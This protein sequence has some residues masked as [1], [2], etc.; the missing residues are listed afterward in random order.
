[1]KKDPIVEKIHKI[2]EKYAA[3]F[4]RWVRAGVRRL[5]WGEKRMRWSFAAII[6][7]FGVIT[8]DL[9]SLK[10]SVLGISLFSIPLLL[11]FTNYK[12]LHIWALWG[13][14]FFIFQSLLS[15]FLKNIDFNDF[16]TLQPNMH[17]I[18]DVKAG[19]PGINGKQLVT[20]DYKGFR[21]TR[22]IDYE[23]SKSYR[24][25]AI[26]GST[27]EQIYLDDRNTW[28]HLLQEHLSKTS[29]L[30]VINTGVSG[31]R[32]KHHLATFQKIIG[33]HPDLVIFLVGIND[34]N[35][36]I[37]EAF[38]EDN[39]GTKIAAYRRA[40]FLLKETLIG[41]FLVKF[42]VVDKSLNNTAK[43]EVPSIREEYG[44]YYSKQR[45]S[46]SRANVFSFHPEDV[47]QNYKKHLL[48][49]SNTCHENNIKCLFI[50]QPTGYQNDANEEFKKGFWMTPP[51]E[52]YTL[53]FESMVDIAFLY[54]S[55]LVR[56][57]MN[58]DHYACDAASVLAPT[59]E[60]FY[61]DC[62][63]NTKGAKNMSMIVGKCIEGFQTSRPN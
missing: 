59:F 13:G 5:I 10:W 1:M 57:S 29:K 51:N 42:L 48:E 14:F 22:D 30:E 41:K 44:E 11:Q 4:Q 43:Y 49:I 15:P 26:G 33:L 50:T 37:K 6:F 24:I 56:F 31:L 16:K 8:I 35:W 60:N 32:A 45:D 39:P 62:H 21:T 52:P 53:D 12:E 27:T 18:V 3:K 25:F 61:D 19:I 55:F 20:T 58:N 36:H 2:I 17:H 47:H 63:F 46:L 7:L 23:N 34:W 38:S 9:E 54:N 28:T 40:N